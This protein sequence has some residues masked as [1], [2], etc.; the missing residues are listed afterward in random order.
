MKSKFIASC[1]LIF[2]FLTLQAQE[3]YDHSSTYPIRE[4]GT[5][6]LNCEDADVKISGTESNVVAVEVHR[7]VGG[8]LADKPFKMEYTTRNGDFYMTE[9]KP[10]SYFVGWSGGTI[11]KYTIDLQVPL[12]VALNITGEDDSYVISNIGGNIYLVSEDGHLELTSCDSKDIDVQLEDGDIILNDLSAN[13]EITL[14]DGDIHCH[15][16]N[17]GNI[18][19]KSEDG[20]IIF[21]NSSVQDIRAEVEDGDIVL[22]K[23]MGDS[24]MVA[25]DGHI[26][27]RLLEGNRARMRTEDG[28]ISAGLHAG[29]GGN[30]SFASEDGDISIYLEG[31][32]GEIRMRCDDCDISISGHEFNYVKDKE[33]SKIMTTAIEGTAKIEIATNDGDIRVK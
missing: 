25:E 30:Y 28:D 19:L 31:E 7:H 4:G 20:D 5:V 9:K 18:R 32:G 13:L 26:K 2:G 14:E 27:I 12:D 15:D 24:E 22:D 21:K 10:D 23:V 11:Y 33:N 3:K 17:L 8:K 16:S 29:P 6:Y 1:F